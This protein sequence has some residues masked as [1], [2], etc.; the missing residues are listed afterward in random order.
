MKKKKPG[1][2]SLAS[3]P[4]YNKIHGATMALWSSLRIARGL[5][6]LVGQKRQICDHIFQG[7]HRQLTEIA[8]RHCRGQSIRESRE[9]SIKD[10]ILGMARR[11]RNALEEIWK[12]VHS[13]FEEL[14]YHGIITPKVTEVRKQE[15]AQPQYHSRRRRQRRESSRRTTRGRM[16]YA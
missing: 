12:L 11:L 14:K 2:R 1:S 8:R 13:L 3:D 16:R 7:G 15:E 6:M 5:G 9:G 10:R 4:L